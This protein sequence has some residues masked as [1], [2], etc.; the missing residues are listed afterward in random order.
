MSP[1]AAFFYAGFSPILLSLAQYPATRWLTAFFLPHMIAPSGLLLLGIRV[2]GSVLFVLGLLIFLACAGQVYFNKFARRG[3]AL[4]GLYSLIRHPQYVGLILAG[5][6][7]AILWPRFIVVA[8]WPVMA[9]LYYFLAKDEERRMLRQH[10][11]EYRQY[12]GK[13]GMFFPASVEGLLARAPLPKAEWV[14][15]AAIFGVVACLS[16][17]G[18]FAMR[19]YSIGQIPHWSN[20]SI[21]AVPIL[22]DDIGKLEHRMADILEIPEIKKRI[23]DASTGYL[24]YFMQPNYIMQGL[25]ADTGERWGLYRRHRTFA[26]FLDW[27]FHPFGH[28][29]GGHTDRVH[30]G[31]HLGS[32]PA[33]NDATRR[34]IFLRV[35]T[36][37]ADPTIE[38]L[39]GINAPRI[40][41][42]FADVNVHT[43]ELQEV[44]DLPS[45]TAW[46]RVPTPTF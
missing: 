9:L 7:L 45:G 19:F 5:I 18:A 31:T 13:T 27:V 34:L 20:G 42:F 8:L 10:E 12:M 14:R 21:T 25:I 44:H 24:V 33:G 2:L 41:S 6:G 30:A 26:N 46:W 40:P 11:N 1:F 37:S 3:V 43:G 29:E 35:E 36:R 32:L 4:R 39:F 38:A 23:Q 28:L 22:T 17:G 16:L 15:G